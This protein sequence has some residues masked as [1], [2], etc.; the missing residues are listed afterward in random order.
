[1][2]I[3]TEMESLNG[4]STPLPP[5]PEKR[6]PGRPR[7]TAVDPDSEV[8]DTSDAEGDW[9]VHTKNLSE[10]DWTQ[11]IV[12]CVRI[13]PTTEKRSA[14]RKVPVSTYVR[15]FDFE[16][17]KREHGS[18]V[19]RLDFLVISQPSGKY[20][21]YRQDFVDI[22]DRECP[23][24]LPYGEWV[25]RPENEAWKWAGPL[26]LARDSEQAAAL[27]V[28]A[29]AAN[30]G[31]AGY[32]PG[33]SMDKVYDRAEQGFRTAFEMARALTPP[34][35]DDS[36]LTVLVGKLIE[37][38]LSRPEPKPDAAMALVVELLRA[39]LK[40]AREEMREMRKVQ[41]APPPQPKGLLEQ[42]KELR[43]MLTE[44]AEIF[45][46]KTGDRPWW[47]GPLEK[48]M[49]SVP[50]VIDLVKTG[51]QNVAPR[52]AAPQWNS[53]PPAGIPAPQTTAPPPQGP[54]PNQ[55]AAATPQPD[56]PPLTDEQKQQQELAA[57]F[58]KWGP[59]VMFIWPQMIEHFKTENGAAFRDWFLRGH[60][61]FKWADLRRELGPDI[62]SLMIAQHQHFS[63]EMA[64]PQLRDQFF[65]DFFEAVPDEGDDDEDDPD[66]GVIN[67][68]GEA[69]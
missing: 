15:P 23:P 37:S 51:Q 13:A 2:A 8:E 3:V 58:Q 64:P 10:D 25:D 27:G 56:Q 17:L 44:Y 49:E 48:L 12:Y 6:R 29:P 31:A 22:V 38:S 54:P 32:P 59:F 20:R 45:A 35:K 63:Q 67:I 28:S 41:T 30:P 43:P 47:S 18:G 40:E 52:P 62:M 53:P 4:T 5:V 36:A 14:G 55:T 65:V 21:R 1:M 42:V 19:Y 11:R 16:D 7:K 9:Q 24:N 34:P 46:E 26:L 50:D 39:D 68:G 66:D 60:G 61:L 57:L 33:F 69:A